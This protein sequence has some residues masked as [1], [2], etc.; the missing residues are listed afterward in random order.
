MVDLKLIKNQINI[1]KEE[2]RDS[3]RLLRQAHPMCG[4]FRVAT[5]KL[6]NNHSNNWKK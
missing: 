5:I 2:K 3:E 4:K 1:S 6:Q